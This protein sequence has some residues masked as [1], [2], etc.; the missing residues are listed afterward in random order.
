VFSITGLKVCNIGTGPG[1]EKRV[2]ID[3]KWPLLPGT[4]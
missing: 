1:L 2:E 4:S 3:E